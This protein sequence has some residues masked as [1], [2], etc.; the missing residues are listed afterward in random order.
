MTMPPWRA[1][2]TRSKPSWSITGSM[3]H[4]SRQHVISLPTLKASTIELGVSALGSWLLVNRA[5]LNASVHLN[6]NK[7]FLLPCA[8]EQRHASL[9]T[10]RR[11]RPAEA[12]PL[13]LQ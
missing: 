13:L 4:G 8:F 9:K 11:D 7:L 2:F 10:G 6:C 1:S 12:S 3:Q 5:N